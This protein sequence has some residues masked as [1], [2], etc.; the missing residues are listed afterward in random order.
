[1]R[2]RDRWA[3]FTVSL[4]SS[5]QLERQECPARSAVSAAHRAKRRWSRPFDSPKAVILPGLY[6][7]SGVEK[8]L[9]HSHFYLAPLRHHQRLSRTGNRDL[10]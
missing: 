6:D 10:K 3:R 7:G 5:P 8:P 9:N 2:R 1:M 4:G